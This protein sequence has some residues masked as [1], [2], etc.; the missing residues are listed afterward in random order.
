MLAK[1]KC[2]ITLKT[3]EHRNIH[4][5]FWYQYLADVMVKPKTAFSIFFR[6]HQ[7][8]KIYQQ[9]NDRM[10]FILVSFISGIIRD[11]ST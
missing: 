10:C 3:G 7:S 9:N 1:C 2:P 4:I 8:S 5:T 6:M 11:V